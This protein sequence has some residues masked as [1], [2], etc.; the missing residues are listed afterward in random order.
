MQGKIKLL[1]CSVLLTLTSTIAIAESDL[2]NLRKRII[3]NTVYVVGGS[4]TGTNSALVWDM[5]KK[6]DDGHDFRVVTVAGR[7]SIKTVED[8]LLLPGIDAGTV[9]AD[10]MDF[11]T[12][13]QIYPNLPNLVR[14]ITALHSEEIHIV[15]TSKYNSVEELEGKKV[16]FGPATSGTFMTASVVFDNLG[17]RVDALSESYDRGLDLLRKGEI[18]AIVRVA[19]A[20]TRFLADI[21]KD[22]ALKL[23][24]VPW[25]EGPYER[26]VLTSDQYSG[27][28][29]LGGE[30]ETISVPSVLVAYNH[31]PGS[32]RHQRVDKLVQRMKE[33]LPALQDG[34]ENHPKW[35]EVDFDKEVAGWIPWKSASVD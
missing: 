18:D 17:L 23:L 2:S 15:S 8:I 20:P 16:N 29:P 5:A 1:I 19:G 7:G 13:Y 26:A 35:A 12:N 11:M 9:Q 4:L 34:S 24:P 30:V 22:E 32:V 25:F 21:S 31:P 33:N 14:Y 6:F 28:V 3:E 27:L 10:V